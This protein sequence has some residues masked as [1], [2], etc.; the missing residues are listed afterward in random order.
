MKYLLLNFAV[1]SSQTFDTEIPVS[2]G[3]KGYP[4]SQFQSLFSN[5]PKPF[6]EW[7][8]EPP[9]ALR[10]DFSTCGQSGRLGP[11][12]EQCKEAYRD[13]NTDKVVEI[14]HGVQKWKVPAD[15]LY[16]ITARGA[17]GKG[18][19]PIGGGKAAVLTGNFHLQ[20]GEV[21]Q[22]LVGQQTDFDVN[23]ISGRGN[24]L[25]TMGIGG[26]GGTFVV[27]ESDDHILLAAG[28]GGSGSGTKWNSRAPS[29]SDA[30]TESYG[31][32]ASFTS[33]S[34]SDG[35]GGRDGYG[36][37]SGKGL[38]G[39]GAGGGFK[40]PGMVGKMGIANNFM[41]FK[42]QPLPGQS[43]LATGRDKGVGGKMLI[44]HPNQNIDQFL[45]NNG[46]FG[47]GGS[48]GF[49]GTAGGGG[50]YSGGGGS[51]L[52]GYSGGGGSLNNGQ[53]PINN[54][55]HE[56]PGSVVITFI[57]KQC[58]GPV[59]VYI[60]M[61]F[62]AGILVKLVLTYVAY[63][64]YKG[65]GRWHVRKII[66]KHLNSKVEKNPDMHVLKPGEEPIVINQPT[67]HNWDGAGYN[68]YM[69][70]VRTQQNTLYDQNQRLD[71]PRNIADNSEYY[72]Y[73]DNDKTYITRSDLTYDENLR[74]Y[75]TRAKDL[76]VVQKKLNNMKAKNNMDEEYTYITQDEVGRN[77]EADSAY[78]SQ[79]FK[80]DPE[81]S[82]EYKTNYYDYS[83]KGPDYT[84]RSKSREFTERIDHSSSTVIKNKNAGRK[85]DRTTDKTRDESDATAS[86]VR[87][88]KNKT[89]K[90]DPKSRTR[91]P[92][93][94]QANDS[95]GRNSSEEEDP[96]KTVTKS[97][98]AINR[99]YAENFSDGDNSQARKSSE[100]ESPAPGQNQITAQRDRYG[101]VIIKKSQSR[102]PGINSPFK[103][104]EKSPI[105][106]ESDYYEYNSQARS[107]TSRSKTR[108]TSRS[109]NRS[110]TRSRTRTDYTYE[111]RT[112][113][114]DSR[115]RT[116][117]NS[118]SRT[119]TYD[120][121]RSMKNRKQLDYSSSRNKVTVTKGNE[122]TSYRDDEEDIYETRYT[123]DISDRTYESRSRGRTRSRR[124]RDDYTYDDRTYV[125]AT[126]VR[127][128]SD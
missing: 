16:L 15:G 33:G 100:S 92:T 126:E 102:V 109:R 108:K 32:N 18:I 125:T 11:T 23:S 28:G 58:C 83:T 40:T 12:E 49:N 91:D 78:D 70:D 69:D 104:P 53:R 44:R 36:G 47:G 121:T 82:S 128:G 105:K 37:F 64:S 110:D 45:E 52:N 74:T 31:R 62:I 106:E 111:S 116:R 54:V 9:V 26:S 3:A 89:S 50:G 96:Y 127:S 98:G 48:G 8:L 115:S 65:I 57:G 112:R 90:P 6:E 97:S 86:T 35:Y 19:G 61:S 101:N 46:G 67:Q 107:R 103:S 76:H 80:K 123:S 38:T 79:K 27:R 10:W 14:H 13:T 43:F 75:V 118:Q 1:A 77:P 85:K 20:A 60:A 21:L 25:M 113:K 95:R 34:S 122:S 5:D 66:H 120:N 94:S 41:E 55:D 4:I 7:N 63:C 114:D 119:T 81:Q 124:D 73:D 30:T 99:A 56:G 93:N 84:E 22:I 87:Q 24:Y 2:S 51:G 42:F 68:P 39:G 117:T 88:R 29:Y 59:D 72:T 71:Q 17:S